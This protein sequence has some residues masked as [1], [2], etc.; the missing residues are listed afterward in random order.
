MAQ[1]ARFNAHAGKR[2]R[3]KVN[4]WAHGTRTHV[5]ATDCKVTR[6]DG[7]TYTISAGSNRADAKRKARVA[8]QV[9]P[10]RKNDHDL[11]ARMGSVH[12]YDN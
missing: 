5:V 3:R 8:T 7:S 9:A 2:Q 11:M 12:Q 4:A 10:I 6:A 1:Y